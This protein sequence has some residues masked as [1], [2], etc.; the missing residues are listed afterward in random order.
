MDL[1]CTSTGLA[2]K[3]CVVSVAVG[4]TLL[5]LRRKIVAALDEVWM[6][7]AQT[8]LRVKGGH[9]PLGADRD[10]VSGTCLEAGD[11]LEIFADAT[12]S[13]P[14]VYDCGAP[15]CRVLLSHCNRF[16][17]VV[18]SDSNIAVFATATALQISKFDAHFSTTPAF[19][20]CGEWV[21]SGGVQHEVQIHSTTTGELRDAFR[22]HTDIT[23]TGWSRC[24]RIV[25]ASQD[26]CVRCWD[27]SGG[28]LWAVERATDGHALCVAG[29]HVVVGRDFEVC[30]RA[31]ASGDVVHT[32]EH[33]A[34]YVCATDDA[35]FVVSTSGHDERLAALRV[36]NLETF[37]CVHELDLH[38]LVHCAA[39]CTTDVFASFSTCSVR[40]WS[41]KTGLH[42]RRL[43]GQG[44]LQERDHESS[45]TGLALSACGRIA[46]VADDTSIKVLRV[47]E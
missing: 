18:C 40:L 28:V 1:S 17:C 2:G 8:G 32:F 23:Q 41:L 16:L 9:V 42:L 26:G 44:S 45:E 31:L 10:L 33:C 14:A 36:L 27:D 21:S 35:R 43:D 3:T 15:A 30:V 47:E 13:V 22:A 39:V 37:T 46:F 34:T 29:E 4:E 6:D 5:S 38:D 11:A 24:G 7:V 19:S 25:S 20:P 12:I